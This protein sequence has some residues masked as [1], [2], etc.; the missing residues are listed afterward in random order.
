MLWLMEDFF[1]QPIRSYIKVHENAKK[2]TIGQREK[3]GFCA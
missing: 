3:Y 2:S 1:N